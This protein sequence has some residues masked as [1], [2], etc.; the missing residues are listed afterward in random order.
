[1]V[2]ALCVK[3]FFEL[4]FYDNIV[5]NICKACLHSQKKAQKLFAP[6]SI[7]DPGQQDQSYGSLSQN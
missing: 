4:G 5:N 2:W 7:C 6:K 3:P 1:M